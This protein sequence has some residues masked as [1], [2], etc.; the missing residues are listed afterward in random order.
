MSV[1]RLII[2]MGAVVAVSIVNVYHHALC[3]KHGYE[4]GS[5]Q[6]DCAEL[7]VSIADLEGQVAMLASPARL[8]SENERMQLALVDPGDWREAER[9][10]AYADAADHGAVEMELLGR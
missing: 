5:V 8:R 9:A 1:R 2:C 10:V 3:V 7:R 4:I 6:A